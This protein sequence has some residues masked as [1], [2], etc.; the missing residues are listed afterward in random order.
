MES[1]ILRK[2]SKNFEGLIKH[3]LKSLKGLWETTHNIYKGEFD[4]DNKTTPHNWESFFYSQLW[5]FPFKK[6][7][8]INFCGE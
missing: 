1:D 7:H 2:S 3:Q 5:S 6:F 8:G 4:S